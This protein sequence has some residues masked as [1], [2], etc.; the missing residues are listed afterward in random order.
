MKEARPGGCDKPG[1][2]L[3][4]KAERGLS[5]RRAKPAPAAGIPAVNVC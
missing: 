2:L 5:P 1:E 3:S 4:H